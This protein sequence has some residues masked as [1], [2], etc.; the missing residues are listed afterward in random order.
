MST[1]SERMKEALDEAGVSPADLARACQVKPPSVSNWLSGETK[2]LKASTAIRASDF[3]G[4]N[5]LWLTEGRGPKRPADETL[6]KDSLTTTPTSIGAMKLATVHSPSMGNNVVVIRH[7]DTGGAMGDGGV[8]LRDQPGLIESWTVT[9]EWI[10]K[11]I[12]NCSAAAN[13]CVVTGFGDSMRPLYEPGD[14]LIVDTGV[15]QV[16]FDGIYFFRVGNEG[17]I[18]RLQRIPGEGLVAISE[19]KA[20]REWTIRD[21][22]DF[23]VFGRIVKAW[24]SEDY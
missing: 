4:V 7:Y 16:D 21:G 5:Q 14:P 15:K 6:G 2:S 23:E 9:P 19:N 3:L 10:Q 18:K 13:L 1:L 12:K 22:M 20:Y 17:F 8:I 11:N 24:R